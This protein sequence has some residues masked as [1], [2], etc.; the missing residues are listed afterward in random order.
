MSEGAMR[1]LENDWM[2][3]PP[4]LQDRYAE[5]T[6]RRNRW[7]H[8]IDEDKFYEEM[9]FKGVTQGER[10]LKHTRIC[11]ENA[12]DAMVHEMQRNPRGFAAAADLFCS[13]AMGLES[14]TSANIA[15][16]RRVAFQLVREIWPEIA[17]IAAICGVQ[18]MQL[19]SQPLFYNE[20]YYTANGS[21]YSAGDRMVNNQDPSYSNFTGGVGG[22]TPAPSEIELRITSENVTAEAKALLGKWGLF[23]EQDM[24]VYHGLSTQAEIAKL[25]A[26]KI[27]RDILGTVVDDL[28]GSANGGTV[29]WYTTP[30]TSSEYT[31][32]SAG[33]KR[34]Q[35]TLF[36]A[37]QD[38]SDFIRNKVY[39][40]V[41]WVM[42]NIDTVSRMIKASG[43]EFHNKGTMERFGGQVV[44]TTEFF[45]V[46]NG[47]FAV[48]G[49]PDMASGNLLCGVTPRTWL[50]TGY[51]F[52]EYVPLTFTD[53]FMDPEQFQPRMAGYT[54]YAR[55]LV[56]GAFYGRVSIQARS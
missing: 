45:G 56:N 1:S 52:G 53:R 23:T 3:L 50:E 37:V 35:R 25:M 49:N 15:A 20:S 8:L 38:V 33:V 14:T 42:G 11:C 24:Q 41:G 44:Q 18:T 17:P 30:A 9:T 16:F 27:A 51:L 4:V 7:K 40:P 21:F 32:D 36:D 31:L 47:L 29:I 34:W 46:L 10:Y 13:Q 48:F 22:S 12:L 5:N 55:H 54:R 6:D 26:M 39:R 43:F 28:I 2:R 19:P